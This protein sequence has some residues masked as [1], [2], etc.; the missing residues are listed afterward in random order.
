MKQMYKVFI[1]DKELRFIHEKD[2]TGSD[3]QELPAIKSPSEI[4][5][6]L[7]SFSISSTRIFCIRSSEPE[8][9]F[10]K[11]IRDFPL[12]R[13]AGGVVRGKELTGPLLMIHRLGKW[14]LPKGKIDPGEGLEEAALREVKEECGI[15]K[16]QIVKKLDDTYHIY[17]LKG[18][19]V[20]K[21]TYWYLM[22]SQ[23]LT[24]LTPQREE[25]ITEAKWVDEK[26]IYFLLPHSYSSI[27]DL[28]LKTV[29]NS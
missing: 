27:A 14:D 1:N 16:L 5:N 9:Y 15:H 7:Q 25:G 24:K 10:R 13:A 4:V 2:V 22:L 3:G 8:H 20:I 18:V 26:D 29:L 11:F 19:T 21:I 12:I 23:E 17:E 28:L 6:T